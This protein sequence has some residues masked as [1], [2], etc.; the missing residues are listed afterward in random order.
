MR[1]TIAVMNA[2]GGVGKSN[3]RPCARKTLA[4]FTAKVCLSIDA[5]ARPAS[6]ICW[7][8]SPNSGG[9][10][11]SRTIVDYLIGAVLKIDLVARFR[12]RRRFRR[13]RRA[14]DRAHSERYEPDAARAR[15]LQ[16]T[17]RHGFAKPSARALRPAQTYDDAS[18]RQPT[19]LSVL[20]E[21]LRA[22]PNPYLPQTS[23][24]ISRRGA[25]DSCVNS[26][27]AIPRSAS[28][29]TRRHRQY[30]VTRS[31]PTTT[32]DR[33]ATQNPEHRCSGNKFRR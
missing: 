13:R 25:W 12:D 9:P 20:T 27:S 10:I 6:A 2:K 3:S 31:R 33:S 17:M 26:G 8:L 18:D 11:G 14:L 16:A 24:T 32:N 29:T 22:R 19:E 7:R 28:A 4:T 1:N 21:V 5:D 15:S 23:R 30:E